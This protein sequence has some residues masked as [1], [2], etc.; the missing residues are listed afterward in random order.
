MAEIYDALPKSVKVG[1]RMDLLTERLKHVQKCV[2]LTRK[3]A[4]TQKQFIDASEEIYGRYS[5][6]AMNYKLQDRIMR[7]ERLEKMLDRSNYKA[8]YRTKYQLARRR[9]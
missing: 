1:E 2:T 5:L 8:W 9:Y 7:Y 4:E 6:D 3:D